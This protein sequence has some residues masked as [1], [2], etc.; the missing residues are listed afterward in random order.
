ML[1]LGTYSNVLIY[2]YFKLLIMIGKAVD[3][4]QFAHY[5][6]LVKLVLPL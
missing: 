2:M 3:N 6:N 4:E 1:Q 5:L